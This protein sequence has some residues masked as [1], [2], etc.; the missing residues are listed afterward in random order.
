MYECWLK[1]KKHYKYLCNE[2]TAGTQNA[3]KVVQPLVGARKPQQA[4][5]G[6][7]PPKHTS[8]YGIM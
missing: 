5:F 4:A 3:H 6:R 2:N 7:S 8:G 1:N